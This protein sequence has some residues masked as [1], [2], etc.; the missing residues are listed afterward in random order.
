MKPRILFVNGSAEKLK[1]IVKYQLSCSVDFITNSEEVL[2][3]DPLRYDVTIIDASDDEPVGLRRC[4]SE[5]LKSKNP[6]MIIIGTGFK[7]ESFLKNG[8][9]KQLYDERISFDLMDTRWIERIKEI[10]TNKYHFDFS[11]E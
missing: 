9:A 6:D 1:D 10:L 7:G 3:K 11:D 5:Y 4:L 8:L 2:A